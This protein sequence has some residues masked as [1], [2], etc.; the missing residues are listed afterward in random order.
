MEVITGAE[1]PEYPRGPYVGENGTVVAT[2]KNIATLVK[3][4]TEYKVQD[5][6]AES[7]PNKNS[8]ETQDNHKRLEKNS[9][10]GELETES[11]K[12][13]AFPAP[14]G[15][16]KGQVVQVWFGRKKRSPKGSKEANIEAEQPQETQME[17]V[18]DSP[19][20]N[21]EDINDIEDIED[22]E[23]INNEENMEDIEDMEDLENMEDVG[24]VEDMEDI[25][26]I[27]DIDA[28]E[29]FE[30]IDDIEVEET[31]DMEEIEKTE[32]LEN[33]IQTGEPEIESEEP[34]N[35][36]TLSC[37]AI[38]LPREF[39]ATIWVQREEDT[40]GVIPILLAEEE[41][42]RDTGKIIFEKL[43]LAMC[44]HLKPLYIKAHMDGRPVNRVLVD[45]GAAVNI[46]PT[47]MLRKLLKT[48]NDLIATDVSVSGFA[49]GATKTK[50]V[51]P[52][53][54]KVGSKVATVAF[55]VVNTDSAYNA[56][57]GRDWIHSNWVVPSSLHQVLV[58]WKDDNNIE[59]VKADERPFV[60]YNNNVD[61]Q[62]YNDCVG[63]VK[64]TGIDQNGNPSRVTVGPEEPLTMEDL[65]KLS[66]NLEKIETRPET[67]NGL[68][69][70]VEDVE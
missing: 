35:G 40:R 31:D 22:I 4:D 62:L 36:K 46:L 65:F 48:E 41:E 9:E 19:S 67:E 38:T 56:L 20:K 5:T 28:F 30:G 50:G 2:T 3:G 52:I 42:C 21:A 45:N 57:L 24:D 49:S 16:R 1:A 29:D 53:E 55:F 10:N 12:N 61:A 33:G 37:N 13:E 68:N 44:Q 25:E 39:M 51:I 34:R 18:Q 69:Y 64:F 14:V 15:P 23:D 54:V 32:T 66:Q 27:E 26:N 70:Y 43:T 8:T 7:Y 63:I 59:V 6:R 58:F 60:T 11:E 47:S 17:N